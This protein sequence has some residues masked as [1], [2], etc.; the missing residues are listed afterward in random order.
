MNP[1]EVIPSR[2][3]WPAGCRLAA[4]AWSGASATGAARAYRALTR[5]GDLAPAPGGWSLHLNLPDVLHGLTVLRIANGFRLLFDRGGR[6]A[7]TCLVDA[8]GCILGA[9]T[10]SLSPSLFS[11]EHDV[12]ADGPAQWIAAGATAVYLLQDRA[13]TA[14][15]FC[16]VPAASDRRRAADAAAAH[17]R[18]DAV[19][20]FDAE[21]LRRTRLWAGMRPA[22]ARS[23][24]VSDAFESLVGLLMPPTGALDRRWSRRSAGERDV[25]HLNDVFPLAMAWCAADPEVAVD[26]VCAAFAVQ[27][28]DGSLPA[29]CDPAPGAPPAPGVAW[30]LFAQACARVHAAVGN[31]TF[32]ESVTPRLEK[33]LSWALG[34]YDPGNTGTPCWPTAPE[35]LAPELFDEHLSTADLTVLL[36]CE[37][38]AFLA[39]RR[40]APGR[41]HDTSRW[42][43]A[44]DRL[45][46][47]L[48]NHL[49]DPATRSYPGRYA[50]GA[51]IER[52]SVSAVLPLLRRSLRPE[53]KRALVRKVDSGGPLHT[54]E[55][56]PLWE[57]WDADADDAPVRAAHQVLVLEGLQR[58]GARDEMERLIGVLFAALEARR[59]A[60]V[61]PPSHVDAASTVSAVGDGD[62]GF[63]ALA[64]CLAAGWRDATRG[65]LTPRPLAWLDRH[66][67][68]MLTAVVALAVCVVAGVSILF[69][70][71]KKLP[72]SSIEAL[73][74][75]ARQHAFE[76]RYDQAVDLYKE[77]MAKSDNAPGIEFLLGN[78]CARRGEYSAAEQHY[79]NVL[80]ADAHH[81]PATLNLA[82]AVYRQGRTNEAV[83]LYRKVARTG[84][85]A[86][87]TLAARARE[88]LDVIAEN[89]GLPPGTYQP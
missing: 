76:G 82:L 2:S 37:I 33:Y 22:A 38:D 41:S 60:A 32:A 8:D 21:L 77:L 54:V 28:A 64:V 86:M 13:G 9:A 48:E 26:I 70:M 47:H 51:H 59:R 68:A 23:E 24:T 16:L 88:A 3:A 67:A 14:A 56:V 69:H 11:A 20:R 27:R 34:H 80:T 40:E 84:D 61:A 31:P 6:A 17:L 63:C 7:V 89:A 5:A 53:R 71:K 15:R 12:R 10:T 50:R 39:L 44:R 57:R 49:W 55:G 43:A 87:P 83:E 74:G 19:E 81:M 58:A 52:V 85:R 73:A 46:E 45:A 30:P 4:S 75:L 42:Q 62:A 36:A 25:F 65:A 18:E 66:R 72:R 29:V 79:L 35:S 78:T 1:G